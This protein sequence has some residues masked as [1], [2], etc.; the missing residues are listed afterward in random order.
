MLL[1]GPPG[2]ESAFVSTLRSF[3]MRM[4]TECWQEKGLKY[5]CLENERVKVVFLPE[6]GGKMIEMINKMT[7]RQFLLPPSGEEKPYRPAFYGA[8]FADYDASGFDE[9]FP[10]ISPSGYFAPAA[11][12]HSP[13]LFFPDH[14]ELWSQPWRYEIA[15]D[16]VRLQAQGV[17]Q[18]YLFTKKVSLRQNKIILDYLLQNSSPFPFSYIWA[19]HPLL[20]VTPGNKLLLP[21][22]IDR[23][24]LNWVSDQQLG[25]FGTVLPWPALF[26]PG[27]PTD[28]SAVQNGSHNLAVKCFTFALDRGFAGVYYQDSDETLLFQFDPAAVPYLGVWLCYGGWPAEEPGKHFT[29]ALEP[30]SGRPD[31]LEIAIE[32]QECAHIGAGEQ[33]QWRLEISLWEG[34]RVGD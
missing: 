2:L 25:D 11:A 27:D 8:N 31:S 26:A 13:A 14:G 5:L 23:V 19:A 9:C 12:A 29:V 4:N 24:L 32:R 21:E 20:R 1:P 6:I 34:R 18:G 33:K 15:G 30:S 16:E 7:G 17:R 22:S 10:T 3:R 28:Y